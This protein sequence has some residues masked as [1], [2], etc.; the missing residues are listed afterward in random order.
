M[1]MDY[2]TLRD[3]LRIIGNTFL[4]SLNPKSKIPLPGSVTLFEFHRQNFNE[5]RG[6][7]GVTTTAAG[8]HYFVEVRSGSDAWINRD[9]MHEL[10]AISWYAD[11]C[12]GAKSWDQYKSGIPGREY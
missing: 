11:L 7:S 9:S 10:V 5:I 3:N 12:S 4:V 6:A 2:F 8:G 1:I